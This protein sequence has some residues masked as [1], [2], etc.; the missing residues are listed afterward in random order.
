MPHNF[1]TKKRMP[2]PLFI[3]I[4]VL[5]NAFLIYEIFNDDSSDKYLTILAV[6]SFDIMF[7]LFLLSEYDIITLPPNSF[8]GD[9]GTDMNFQSV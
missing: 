7:V 3:A 6:V 4:I 2:I 8:A 1:K 9:N 5:A